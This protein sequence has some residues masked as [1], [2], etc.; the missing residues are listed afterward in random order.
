MKKTAVIFALTVFALALL[1]PFAMNMQAA[2]AQTSSYT[3]QE[4]YQN[5]QVLNSGGVVVSFNITLS[6]T[7][8]SNFLIGMPYEYSTYV[9][10]GVAYD[11][12]YNVLPVTLGVQLQSQSGFYAASVALPSG[13]TNSFTVV[14]VFSNSAL[15]ETA[16]GFNLY[17]PAY[18]ALTQVASDCN[19]TITLPSGVSL[20]GIDKNDGAVNVTNYDATNLAPFTYS[21]GIGRIA[22][23]TGYIQPVDIPSLKRQINI[24]ASGGITAVDTY[25]FV[26]ESQSIITALLINLPLNATN[27]SARDQFGTVLT[28]ATYQTNSQVFVQNMTLAIPINPGEST[29]ITVYYILPRVSPAQFSRYTLDL[30]LLPYLNCYVDSASITITPP[31]GATIVMPQISQIGPSATL[32][33]NAFQETLT[34]NEQ[35]VSFV[36]SI[37]PSQNVLSF[38]FDYSPLWI[39]FRPTI[40]MFAISAVGLFVVAYWFRPKTKPTTPRLQTLRRAAGMMSPE[41]VTAFA[42]A[43][44]EKI[45]IKSDMETLEAR[46]AHG[47][48]PRRRYK[49]QR[50]AMEQRVETLTNTISRLK[51]VLR[52]AG[53]TYADIVRQLEAGEVELEEAELSLKNLEVRHETGEV[54]LENY[55]KQLPD[56]EK[57][58]EKAESRINELLLRVREEIR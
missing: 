26:D 14:F 50:Q 52:S 38:T 56:V 7:L 27:I 16:S 39:A 18:P 13:T 1:L 40:W 11:N 41:T 29:G 30:D 57:R 23:S 54:S 44:E 6:G 51:Q 8:P 58:K 33:R 28:I 3:I 17:Y 43:Y 45:K 15:A 36:D 34:I 25:R 32:S 10:K 42:D 12:N 22:V 2:N 5:V 53:G 4:V 21:P 37:I 47:R 46:V 20:S 31:E 9:V 24:D 35:G 49:V 55:R 19:V 48:I